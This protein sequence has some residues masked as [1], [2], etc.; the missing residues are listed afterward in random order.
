MAHKVHPKAFRIHEMKDWSSR[1]FYENN[2]AQYLAEDLK[3]RD[4][5]KESLPK[6][7]V[8]N[9]D[10]ERSGSEIKIIIETV[11]PGLIIGRGGE[12]VEKIKKEI[13]KALK[14][15]TTEK[16][17]IKIEVEEIKEPWASAALVAQNI[18]QQLEKRIAYRRAITQS[19]EKAMENREVKGIW[20]RISGRL[21]GAEIARQETLKK[22]RIPRQTLRADIDYA[23]VEANCSYGVI[24]VKVL[25]Y[26]GEKFN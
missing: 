2:F 3:M 4:V 9:I 6:A 5:L 11:R 15:T 12:G 19:L 18:A 25:I 14:K 20:I 26:K 10:I 21:N 23:L 7:G 13:E 16:R 24:G 1:G 22:G 17:K 8:A